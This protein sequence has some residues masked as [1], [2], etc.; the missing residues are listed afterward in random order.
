VNEA[1]VELSI[2]KD[3]DHEGAAIELCWGSREPLI[4]TI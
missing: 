2:G 1:Q 4:S 3:P